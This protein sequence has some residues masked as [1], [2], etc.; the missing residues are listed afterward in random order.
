[1]IGFFVQLFVLCFQTFSDMNMLIE[2]IPCIN[3]YRRAFENAFR[4]M[5]ALPSNAEALPPMPEDGDSWSALHSWVM[6]TTSF[7]EFVMFSR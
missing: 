2:I 4:R 5:Y 6:P 7:M 3:T 1:M